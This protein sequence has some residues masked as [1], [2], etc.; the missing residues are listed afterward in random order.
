MLQ[1]GLYSDNVRFS[2]KIN[3]SAINADRNKNYLKMNEQHLLN[4]TYA[5]HFL[6]I[7]R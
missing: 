5:Y 3:H 6:G 2:L 7:F 4:L 1:I